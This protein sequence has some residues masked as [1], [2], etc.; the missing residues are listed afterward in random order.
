MED[1]TERQAVNKIGPRGA[2]ELAKALQENTTL[3]ELSLSREQ[4][5]QQHH[6]QRM[7]KGEK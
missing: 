3:E 2:Q 4:Q 6:H 5:Q 1:N 7:G